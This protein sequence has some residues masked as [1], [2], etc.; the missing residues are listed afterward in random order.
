[1]PGLGQGDVRN[2]PGPPP[3]LPA[4]VLH[5]SRLRADTTY[6]RRR[7]KVFRYDAEIPRFYQEDM[8][9]FDLDEAARQ[10]EERKQD[11]LAQCISKHDTDIIAPCKFW[12]HSN[13]FL[14]I[15]DSI[16]R[17]LLDLGVTITLVFRLSAPSASVYTL[18]SE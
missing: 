9:V 10:S 15:S 13:N 16:R 4:L 1:M 12:I 7:G 5:N 14:F 17:A 8:E 3:P 2:H 6:L 18:S 11:S